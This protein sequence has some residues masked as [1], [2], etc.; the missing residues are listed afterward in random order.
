VRGNG[1]VDYN[2]LEP[3]A[4]HITDTLYP[5][6]KPEATIIPL[7]HQADVVISLDI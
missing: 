1:D 7:D 2:L 6:D 4:C 5:G 3:G